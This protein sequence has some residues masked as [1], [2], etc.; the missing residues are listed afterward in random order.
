M[1]PKRLSDLEKQNIAECYQRS[2]ETITTI[3]KA[4]GISTSTVSRVLKAYYGESGYEALVQQKRTAP[5]SVAPSVAPMSEAITPDA[6]VEVTEVTTDTA[7]AVTERPERSERPERE[8]SEA[9]SS[10]TLE[11]AI[12]QSVEP[13][14][15]PITEKPAA[16]V[17]ESPSVSVDES[18][19]LETASETQRQT[20]T[21]A[22]GSRWRKSRTR[23]RTSSTQLTPDPASGAATSSEMIAPSEVGVSVDVSSDSEVV[24]AETEAAQASNLQQ[25]DLQFRA[26]ASSAAELSTADRRRRRRS[27]AHTQTP[28]PAITVSTTVASTPVTHPVSEAIGRAIRDIDSASANATPRYTTTDTATHQPTAQA[29]AGVKSSPLDESNL[30]Q[31]GWSQTGTTSMLNT[32]N[33]YDSHN[34]TDDGEDGYEPY[35]LYSQSDESDEFGDDE[36][37]DDEDDEDADELA[38][39]FR[40]ASS[41]SGLYSS[42]HP[43]ALTA[44][45]V[46]TT[47]LAEAILPKTCYLVVDRS[48][49]LIAKPL[50]EFS[51]LGEIPSSEFQERTLPI[52]D[53]HR[54]ARRY[55]NRSQR[56]MKIPDSQVLQK[57]GAHLQA[58]G[59]TRILVDGKV[60]SL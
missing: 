38:P 4:F 29:S 39:R 25:M 36:L 1:S 28:E 19:T 9:I 6:T 45:F 32:H 55:A 56:V 44:N 59:I 17:L 49:E 54:V 57:T 31:T 58:K 26:T 15:F 5:R 12:E 3:A 14:D 16:L 60:Y 47:P 41:E 8:R 10:Q 23:S 53:N 51:D 27:S 20:A 11:T 24:H 2:G 37:L 35:H 13:S 40:Y 22:P 34:S 46:T 7:T 48:S 18:S 43:N 52:F 21:E 33:N 50:R 30:P 42:S